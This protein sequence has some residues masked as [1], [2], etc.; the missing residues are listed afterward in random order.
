MSDT[1]GTQPPGPYQ[2]TPMSAVQTW[3]TALVPSETNYERIISDPGL[4]LGKAV[5]WVILAS[6]LSAI[7][8]YG[9]GLV[10][11]TAMGA[12]GAADVQ[13]VGAQVLIQTIT[14]GFGLLCSIPVAIIGFVIV[15]GL[16][17]AT[18]RALGGTGTFTQLAYGFA[19]Q[20]VPLSVLYGILLPI[21]LINFL[22]LPLGLYQTVLGV[23]A[24]KAAHRFG[25]ARAIAAYL[26][27]PIVLTVLIVLVACGTI[28]VLALLGPAIGNVFSNIVLTLTPAP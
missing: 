3:T 24:T 27:I 6:V 11:S 15:V 1:Y 2:P 20:S 10:V 5:L 17:H 13:D 9:V 19:A 4:S 14:S 26:L 18:A 12:L 21:P 8:S 28:V 16:I 23:Y 7:L 22:T 25:W